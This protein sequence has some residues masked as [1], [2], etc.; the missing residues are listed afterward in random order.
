[1][2]HELAQI[3]IVD[4]KPVRGAMEHFYRAINR[5]LFHTPDWEK[6]DPKVRRAISS[7]GVDA[8]FKDVNAA[9]TAETF[10]S[11]TDRHL[12]RIPM[13]LDR[14]GWSE[15]SVLFDATLAA[16]LEIQARSSGRM[17]ESKED[18]IPTLAAMACFERPATG[19][20]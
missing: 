6:F 14:E 17:A 4:E 12:S 11:K 13:L 8:I 20:D 7:Y 10:D 16:I 5:P 18:G 2:L 3:E 15:A 9:L 19:S 1:V